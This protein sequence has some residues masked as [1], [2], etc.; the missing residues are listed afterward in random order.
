MFPSRTPM[1]LTLKENRELQIAGQGHSLDL[2]RTLAHYI[3]LAKKLPGFDADYV[4]SLRV[5]LIGL[6]KRL[7]INVNL[8]CYVNGHKPSTYRNYE[9][10]KQSN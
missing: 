5:A 4:W 1:P 6:C 2:F 3:Y 9:K 7:Y 10:V 8:T